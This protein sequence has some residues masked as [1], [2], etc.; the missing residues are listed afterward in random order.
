[1]DENK[2]TDLQ[3]CTDTG[4]TKKEQELLELLLNPQHRTK[5]VTEICKLADCSRT[6]YYKAFQKPEFKQKYEDEAKELVKQA[7][8][9]VVNT[10]IREALRGSFQHGKVI[11]EMAGIY[12]EK[13]SLDITV[14]VVVDRRKRL[15]ELLETPHKQAID[16]DYEV[17][18]DCPESMDTCDTENGDD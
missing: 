11:L 1:M 16:A 9:P 14:D 7:I 8:G 4:L 2:S 5:T 12:S 17:L 15:L 3:L 13:S 6:V 18:S 10:F